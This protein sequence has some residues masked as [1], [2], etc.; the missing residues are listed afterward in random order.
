MRVCDRV[1]LEYGSD[2][3]FSFIV[4]QEMDETAS[5][6]Y[7][8]VAKERVKRHFLILEVSAGNTLPGAT[9]LSGPGLM[10]SSC[11]I[12]RVTSDSTQAEYEFFFKE[13]IVPRK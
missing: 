8:T 1:T 6:F 7:R 13:K 4:F 10:P 5:A 3:K 12:R 2:G 11:R 9:G